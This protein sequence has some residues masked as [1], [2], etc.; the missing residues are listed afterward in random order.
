MRPLRGK[1][2][3]LTALACGLLAL[4]AGASARAEIWL[5]EDY[6]LARVIL[7][8][9]APPLLR[10]AA[11]EFVALWQ[12]TTRQSIEIV[13]RPETGPAI[14]LGKEAVLGTGLVREWEFDEL[15]NEGYL[16]RTFAPH[17]REQRLS[18][19]YH[20]VIA[21]NTDLATL[22]G[23][24]GYFEDISNLRIHAPDARLQV[25]QRAEGITA[26]DGRFAPRV[27][28]REV[29]Y[30]ARWLGDDNW[31]TWRRTLHLPEE[32][33][34][35]TR[36]YPREWEGGPGEP[37]VAGS[38]ETRS[39]VELAD[40]ARAWIARHSAAP[41]DELPR[42]VRFTA[43]WNESD[44]PVTAWTIN[45][46]PPLRKHFGV[47]PLG[48]GVPDEHVA[49]ALD[50]ANRVA[51]QLA[52]EAEGAVP[53]VKLEL[54][55]ACP[56][57]PEDLALQPNM[58]IQLSNAACDF[59]QS[60]DAEHT[61]ENRRFV[62]ALRQWSLVA[63]ELFV[64][65][66][67]CSFES[68]FTP[69]P[70]SPDD[71]QRNIYL[72]QRYNVSGLY[73]ESW[74]IPE[75]GESENERIHAALL[76]ELYWNVD[77]LLQRRVADRMTHVYGEHAEVATRVELVLRR[78]L[79]DSGAPMRVYVPA[80]WFGYE[81]VTDFRNFYR[82]AVLTN[83]DLTGGDRVLF[84]PYSAQMIYGLVFC[85]P[86]L[87]EDKSGEPVWVRPSY[88]S[89]QEAVRLWTD[90]GYNVDTPRAAPVQQ[91]FAPY[92]GEFPARRQPFVEGQEPR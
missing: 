26:T 16:Y 35:S 41:S 90:W 51:E 86:V 48:Q 18:V 58:V 31:R 88:K 83:D 61:P 4:F 60:L 29:G 3:R 32:Y 21:G 65:D 53:L 7:P 92:D 79:R 9:D 43:W 8:E 13:S 91:V 62:E 11:E 77:R 74:D 37:A 54:S 15:G 72:Y 28:F 24:Y 1:S 38:G 25:G 69:F 84:A 20:L 5:A 50:V 71:L 19:G 85:P 49:Q 36:L 81:Q 22:H 45:A 82:D 34:R 12:G 70:V 87:R 75:L 46:I 64:A 56:M 40:A 78:L 6:N 55:A 76:A 39:A 63:P 33:V 42:G 2:F 57:P 52:A 80:G 30:H 66:Y 73:A 67:V 89:K 68:P 47:A 27:Q 44:A 10:F 17:D 14:W 23:V 59:S